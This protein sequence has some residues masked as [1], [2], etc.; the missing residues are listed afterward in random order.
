ML[1]T[2]QKNSYARDG[3]LVL[4]DF[5][6][7]VACAGLRERA[8]ELVQDYDPDAV[9]SLFSTDEQTRTSDDYFLASGDNISFFWEPSAL[10]PDGALLR[11]K[12]LALNK[13][14]HALHDLDEV[15]DAFSRTPELAQLATDLGFRQPALAQSMYL[16]KQPYIG[17]AVTCHQDATFL[18]TEPLTVVGLW[19]AMEDA[20]LENGCLWALPG[21]HRQGLKS[22]FVRDAQ[23]GTR[24]V[25]YD[26]TPWPTTGLVPLAVKAGTLIVLHG[27]LPHLSYANHTPHSRHA[28]TLH[29]LEQTAPYPPDNW[30]RRVSANPWRGFA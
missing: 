7:P 18:Y 3:Y 21:G 30:L 10:A 9:R 8:R 12:E 25:V 11:P 23:E 17:G 16:F 26:A 1:T 13:I 24:F 20:T 14:G 6:P 4:P 5:C 22:R 29:L 27:L 28:Y 15:F 19:F 2:E